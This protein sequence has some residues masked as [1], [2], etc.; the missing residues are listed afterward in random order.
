MDSNAALLKGLLAEAERE[1]SMAKKNAEEAEAAEK[2]N[3]ESLKDLEA[4]IIKLRNEVRHVV[5]GFCIL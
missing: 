2:A 5:N 1:A 3:E 4:S